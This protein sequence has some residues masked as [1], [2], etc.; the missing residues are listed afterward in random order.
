M[1]KSGSEEFGLVASKG[2]GGQEEWSRETWANLSGCWK[3][4]W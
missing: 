2:S 3:G 1:R 4:G